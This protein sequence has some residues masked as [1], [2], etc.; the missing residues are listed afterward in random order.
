MVCDFI[1]NQISS[2]IHIQT[3]TVK[4]V[5]SINKTIYCWLGYLYF[6]SYSVDRQ[7]KKGRKTESKSEFCPDTAGTPDYTNKVWLTMCL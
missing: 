4:K 1:F 6:E 5:L 2:Y 7:H 3:N